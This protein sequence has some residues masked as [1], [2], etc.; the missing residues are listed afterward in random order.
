M[1]PGESLA[2]LRLARTEGVGPA[3]FRRL[4]GRHGSARAAIEALPRISAAAGR[5]LTPFPAD[6]AERETEELGR[7]GGAWLHLGE[8]GYPPLLALLE[9][10]PPL[11]EVAPPAG[12]NSQVLELIGPT[13]VGVDDLVRRCHLSAPTVRATLLDLELSGLVE[14][15]PGNRVVRAAR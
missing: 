4:L 12:A 3:T 5:S 10:P 8:H 6:A 2:R 13:P 15:L 1:T 14:P 11:E 9:D 7:L